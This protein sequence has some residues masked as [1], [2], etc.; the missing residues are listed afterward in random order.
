MHA[1]EN[2]LAYFV[3]GSMAKK[4]VLLERVGNL[5]NQQ[6]T[7]LVFGCGKRSH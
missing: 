7:D 3:T 2:A 1:R 6:L 5:Q 4:K